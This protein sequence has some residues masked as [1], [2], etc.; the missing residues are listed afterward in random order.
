[1]GEEAALS[2]LIFSL[3]AG[4]LDLEDKNEVPK[5]ET[6]MTNSNII[7]GGI[8]GVSVSGISIGD[9]CGDFSIGSTTIRSGGRT[10]LNHVD[11]AMKSNSFVKK[12]GYISQDVLGG[13]GGQGSTYGELYCEGNH[14]KKLT[15]GPNGR[16]WSGTIVAGKVEQAGKFYGPGTTFNEGIPDKLDMN[17]TRE[18]TPV[19]KK[20]EKPLP[21]P[22]EITLLVPSAINGVGFRLDVAGKGD[23]KTD[24]KSLNFMSFGGAFSNNA[25]FNAASMVAGTLTLNGYDYSK[26]ICSGNSSAII[27]GASDN[28]D[29]KFTHDFSNV[30]LVFL[31]LVGRDYGK[32]DYQAS[33][34]IC[35]GS[36]TTNI[37][38]SSKL[39]IDNLFVTTKK[40]TLALSDYGKFNFSGS[41]DKI[42]VKGK[43]S[44]EVNING[45]R[46]ASDKYINSDLHHKELIST[47]ELTAYAK[48]NT[49]DWHNKMIVNAK[50]QSKLTYSSNYPT[51][52]TQIT[53]RDYAKV[54][55]NTQVK[56]AKIQAKDSAEVSVSAVLDVLE[57]HKE[58]YAKIKVTKRPNSG[59]QL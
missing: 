56:R 7:F 25:N 12:N 18:T 29:L 15:M 48:V 23:S 20:I 45:N 46:M 19:V 55:F 50:E 31:T 49:N 10:V 44:S 5:I 4:G 59:F 6:N 32:I 16:I 38:D 58:D 57:D 28:S 2:N 53:A 39:N 1:M 54:A 47:F 26:V 37:S 27:L 8:S 30:D 17:S 41:F 22:T 43:D 35:K 52:S 34:S 33:G 3:H 11:Y 13:F 40:A 21:K 42:D 51:E 14:L 9:I 36:F 24:I